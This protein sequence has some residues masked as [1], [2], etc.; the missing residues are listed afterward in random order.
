MNK[1]MNNH[2]KKHSMGDDQQRATDENRIGDCIKMNEI[3]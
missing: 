1:V 2:W 3:T